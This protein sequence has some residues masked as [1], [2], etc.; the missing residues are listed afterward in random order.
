M[1]SLEK[2]GFVTRRRVGRKYRVEITEEG[3]AVIKKFEKIASEIDGILMKDFSEEEKQILQ[4]LL[5]KMLRNLEQVEDAK[6][7]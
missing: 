3:K 5:K 6:R 4:N 1:R 2:K 7:G